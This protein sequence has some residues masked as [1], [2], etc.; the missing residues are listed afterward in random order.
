M[1][2]AVSGLIPDE[3]SNLSL[4][5]F[6]NR[7]TPKEVAIKPCIWRFLKSIDLC[8]HIFYFDHFRGDSTVDAKVKIVDDTHQRQ[9]IEEIHDQI[10]SLLIIFFEALI[11]ECEI[12]RHTPALV[13]ASLQ[14]YLFW[15]VDF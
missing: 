5:I 1:V 10:V 11:S 2:R 6:E 12:L 15:V 4:I 8:I 9:S 14:S 7:I 13:V 3:V